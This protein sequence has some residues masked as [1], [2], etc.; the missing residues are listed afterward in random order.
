MKTSENNPR[1]VEPFSPTFTPNP[2]QVMNPSLRPEKNLGVLVNVQ[3]EKTKKENDSN[4]RDLDNKTT[5]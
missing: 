2:P 3:G 5:M 4:H 1:T